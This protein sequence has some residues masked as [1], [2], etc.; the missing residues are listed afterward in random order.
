M[1]RACHA[2]RQLLQNHPSGHLGGWATPRSAEEMPAD[3]QDQT[4]D[5][6]THAGTAYDDLP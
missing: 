1:V 2:P 3:G 4:V 6:P 5:V